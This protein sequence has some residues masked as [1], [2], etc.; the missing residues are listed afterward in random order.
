MQLPETIQFDD[1][2]AREAFEKGYQLQINGDVEGAERHYR[3]SLE[4]ESTAE[5]HT[6]LGWALSQ[7]NQFDEAIE[8]CKK[9]I[10]IDP[11][12]GNPYND[13]GVYLL[14][15]GEMDQARPW[16]NMALDAPRYESYCFPHFNLG[17]IHLMRGHFNE[18]SRHFRLALEEREDFEKAR[19][20]LHRI[21]SRLN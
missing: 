5:G 3:E 8:Q 20:A 14:E 18:A 2:R 13:I 7:R 4:Y 15:Q 17:R 11:D 9:A 6:F 10:D 21:K 16:F 1:E 12:F 19:K